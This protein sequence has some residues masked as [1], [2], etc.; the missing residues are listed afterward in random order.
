MNDKATLI[1]LANQK[2]KLRRQLRRGDVA[3]RAVADEFLTA[4]KSHVTHR[5]GLAKLE[6]KAKASLK[7]AEAAKKTLDMA[8]K[9][10]LKK[11]KAAIPPPPLP[12]P[13]PPP[14]DPPPPLPPPLDPAPPLPLPP[15]P[16]L[17]IETGSG[18]GA[19]LGDPGA[20]VPGSALAIDEEPKGPKKAKD[21]KKKPKDK[22]DKAKKD[23]KHK[24][25]KK[26]KKDKSKKGAVSGPPYFATDVDTEKR[27]LQVLTALANAWEHD[28]KESVL[29]WL[30]RDVHEE[31]AKVR[32]G[33]LDQVETAYFRK[34]VVPKPIPKGGLESLFVA[35]LGAFPDEQR[36]FFFEQRLLKMSKKLKADLHEDDKMNMYCTYV[37]QSTRI[38]QGILRSLMFI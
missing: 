17:K 5:Q 15:Q 34:G 26:H 25:K 4:Y 36:A 30:A 20:E 27:L 7:H 32:K 19:S 1:M 31:A 35:R 22:K 12:P 37:G 33:V 29:R 21:D 8:V 23:K 14:I 10:I 28:K 11:S 13:L 3:D 6:D 9:Q 38:L 2:E 24:K 16:E 18:G